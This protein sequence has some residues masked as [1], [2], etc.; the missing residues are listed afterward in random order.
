MKATIITIAMIDA[1]ELRSRLLRQKTTIPRFRIPYSEADTAKVLEATYESEVRFRHRNYQADAATKGNIAAVAELLCDES[2]FGIMLCGNCG[3][4][5]TT[6]MYAIRNLVN[7]LSRM[8]A[9]TIGNT[10][11]ELEV[12]DAMSIVKRAKDDEL[13]NIAT[14]QMLGIDDLGNEPAEV[15][16]YGNVVN[17]LAELLEIRYK[18]QLYTIVTTNLIPKQIREK[19]GARV[20][21]RLNEMFGVV[22][23]KNSTYRK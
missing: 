5:K 18:R 20:A 19:Y 6:M 22:I 1:E 17:P 4:G 12:M 2:K 23:F 15:M 21:D 8:G 13:M 9:I 16:N 3:N 11:P 7:Y 14:K 10:R